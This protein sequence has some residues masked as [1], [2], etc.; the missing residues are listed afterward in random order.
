MH[1]Y[2]IISFYPPEFHSFNVPFE[3]FQN[4]LVNLVT[5]I[6]DTVLVVGQNDRGFVVRKSSLWLGVNADQI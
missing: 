5:E 1:W 6:F 3:L 4:S 2:M